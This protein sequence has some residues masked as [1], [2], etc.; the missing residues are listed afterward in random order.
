M[1]LLT[2][3]PF[4]DRQKSPQQVQSD[5]WEDRNEILKSDV[6][7]FCWK[8]PHPPEVTNFLTSIAS[9][10]TKAISFSTTLD[11][12]SDSIKQHRTLWYSE[13]ASEADIFW[14]DA[15]KLVNDFLSLSNTQSG[16]VFLKVISDNACTKFHM[17][18]YSLRLFTTYLGP[19]TEWLPEKATNRKGLGQSNERIIKDPSQIQSMETFEVGILKGEIANRLNPTKGI[20][21]RSPEIHEAGEQRIILRVD[22]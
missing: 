18:G 22:I 4:L 15:E 17:D 5:S 14:K 10:G 2:G 1:N 6:N 19:G 11:H 13:F 8:R 9:G 7:L 21:H 16:T 12:L 20:V 3:I